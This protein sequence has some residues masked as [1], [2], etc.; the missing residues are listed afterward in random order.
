MLRLI[1]EQ[2]KAYGLKEVLVT[3]DA[4]NEGSR[5][6]IIRNRGVF[7]KTVHVDGSDIHRYWIQLEK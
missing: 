1:L 2:C 3:C 7:E 6:S 4:T 5:R